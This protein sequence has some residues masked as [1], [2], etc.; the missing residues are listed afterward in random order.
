MN[1]PISKK[2]PLSN[3]LTD[4][5][6]NSPSR[7]SRSFGRI[8]GT[9]HDGQN[10]GT[11]GSRSVIDQSYPVTLRIGDLIFPSGEPRIGLPTSGCHRFLVKSK[12]F[13][14]W[15]FSLVRYLTVFKSL[16][17][18]KALVRIL[19][20]FLRYGDAHA[21]NF[22]IPPLA[23]DIRKHQQAKKAQPRALWCGKAAQIF[24]H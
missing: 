4:H 8:L 6:V 22:L 2:S 1:L 14:R 16:D 15:D 12:N 10:R 20:H 13:R 7:F 21:R 9:D 24:R 11:V 5:W 18:N 17:W 23:P 19:R 3:P